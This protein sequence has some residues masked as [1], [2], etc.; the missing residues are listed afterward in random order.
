MNNTTNTTPRRRPGRP[1]RD[2]NGH[3]ATSHRTYLT[4][5]AWAVLELMVTAISAKAGHNVPIVHVLSN[6]VLEAW[7]N[8]PSNQ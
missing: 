7:A 6:V 3:R 1:R 8:H 5:E 2:A 4:P